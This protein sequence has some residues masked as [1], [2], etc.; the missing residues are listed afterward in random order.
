MS[1]LVRSPQGFVRALQISRVTL[2]VF[3]EGAIDSYFYGQICQAELPGAF[4]YD[5]RRSDQLPTPGEG[6]THL[7]K[8]F[9][10]MK[11]RGLLVIDFKGHKSALVFCLDKDVDDMR[12]RSRTSPHLVYSQYY[13]VE[14]YAYRHGKLVRAVATVC[15]RDTSE[16]ARLIPNPD[17]WSSRAAALWSDWL[18]LCLFGSLRKVTRVVAH[19]DAP[20]AVNPVWCQKADPTLFATKLAE[21]EVSSGKTAQAFRR[22]FSRLSKNVDDLYARGEHDRLFKGKW[23]RLILSSELTQAEI[24]TGGALKAL[25]DRLTSSLLQ[26]LDFSE[27]WAEYHRHAIRGLI[28]FTR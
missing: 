15:Y 10:S 14:N 12:R 2:H 28:A 23:Y 21:V 6:K 25:P 3:V 4:T 20:S 16:V 19:F 26:S 27:P 5:L 24:A 13:E 11:R 1:R 22:S 18:K 17:E 7:L 8:L 9:E